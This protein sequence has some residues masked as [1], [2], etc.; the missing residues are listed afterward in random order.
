MK[1]GGNAQVKSLKSMAL[2]KF[3]Q[4]GKNAGAKM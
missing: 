3:G 2:Q 4:Q 1:L